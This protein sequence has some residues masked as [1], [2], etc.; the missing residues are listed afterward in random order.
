LPEIAIFRSYLVGGKVFFGATQRA[1][2]QTAHSESG[3]DPQA[4][5]FGLPSRRPMSDPSIAA[6]QATVSELL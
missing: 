2:P 3:S 6:F 4:F 5:H 1:R